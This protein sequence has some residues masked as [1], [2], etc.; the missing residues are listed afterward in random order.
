MLILYK[1]GFNY[2][3]WKPQMKEFFSVQ[4]IAKLLKLS[5]S[6]VIYYIKSSQLRAFQVGKVYVVSKE[7]FG[8]FLKKH[9][10]KKKRK[11]ENQTTLEF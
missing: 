3:N 8:E 1:S 5:K 10:A 9:K 2:K 6:S 11:K 4:D 7:D